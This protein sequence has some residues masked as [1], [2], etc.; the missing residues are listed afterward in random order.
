MAISRLM[1]AR[2]STRIGAAFDTHSDASEAASRLQEIVGIGADQVQVLDPGRSAIADV[3]QDDAHG[4]RNVLW[5][6]HVGIS[7]VGL[8]LALIAA[9]ALIVLDVSAFSWRPVY[10]LLTFAFVGALGGLFI[11]GLIT[12]PLD[13]GRPL[14]T[15]AD[16]A[17]RRRWGLVVTTRNRTEAAR[18]KSALEVLTTNGVAV[19]LRAAS[20]RDKLD[21]RGEELA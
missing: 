17:Q 7:A 5:R 4:F 6:A 8:V 11:G 2:A 21:L 3:E 14:A 13:H 18:V 12:L 9:V 16:A 15:D 10:T 1:G 19:T 20:R